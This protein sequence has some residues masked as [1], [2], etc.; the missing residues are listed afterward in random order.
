MRLCRYIRGD[1]RLSGIL[2]GDRVVDLGVINRELGG[3]FPLDLSAVI[4]QGLV[5]DLSRTIGRHSTDL[6]KMGSPLEGVTFTAAYNDPPK[7]L[8][9]GLNYR[10][11][12]ADLDERSPEEP[13]SFMKPTTT[14]VGP[15]EPIRLPGLSDRVTGEA[16]LAVVIGATCKNLQSRRDAYDV[17]AGFVT[18][19]DMTAEDILRRNP[20][21]LTRAKS[22]D[23][24]LSLGS[25]IVTPDEIGGVEALPERTVSTV[26]NGEV[27]R[28]NVVSN[29]R[30]GILELIRFH[31]EVMT[32]RAGD[33]LLTGTPGAVVLGDADVVGCRIDGIG[34]HEST[35]VAHHPGGQSFLEPTSEVETE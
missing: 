24:F 28:R 11:H 23:T 35:V 32:W 21:F 33:L 8:G 14:I 9:I 7:I 27:R 6:T 3:T 12:A 1:Q 4:R 10:E 17:I 25:T 31:S 15:D 13:A 5:E 19:I 16:E 18:A 2:R 20:R 29:M 30:H 34:E 22:F 26:L